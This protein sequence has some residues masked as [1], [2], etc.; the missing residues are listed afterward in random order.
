MDWK[1]YCL[2]S[3]KKYD[4]AIKYY[5]KAIEV[6]PNHTDPWRNKAL[7]FYDLKNY[8]DAISAMTRQ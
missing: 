3:F 1:R 2:S 8:D 7:I 4:E 5:D 6:N